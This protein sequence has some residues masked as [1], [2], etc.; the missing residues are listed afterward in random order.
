MSGL[1]TAANE[2]SKMGNGYSKRTIFFE[3][4]HA[5]Y[6]SNLSRFNNLLVILNI[7]L[8]F[9]TGLVARGYYFTCYSLIL[10]GIVGIA[11]LVPTTLVKRLWYYVLFF[12]IECAGLY[13]LVASIAYWVQDGSSH[14]GNM[15]NL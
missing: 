10:L 14:A 6:W 5:L 15:L 3:T 9:L 4:D 8:F 7:S 12:M 11:A 13:F 2:V 1:A